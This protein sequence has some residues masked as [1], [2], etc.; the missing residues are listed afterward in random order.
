MVVTSQSGAGHA[1]HF[2]ASPNYPDRY[3]R[4]AQCRWQLAT[5]R[6]QS[7]R[8]TIVDFELDTLMLI[9]TIPVDCKTVW[10]LGETLEDSERVWETY[11]DYAGLLENV[12]DLQRPG[13]T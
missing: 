12:V 1:R 4:D 5:Q 8:L 10:G 7:I 6:T 3:F 13:Q 9:G 11:R 2:I